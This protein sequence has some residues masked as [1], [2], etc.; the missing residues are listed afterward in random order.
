MDKIQPT[1]GFQNFAVF[2][3]ENIFWSNLNFQSDMSILNSF[4]WIKAYTLLFVTEIFLGLF[5]VP[6]FGLVSTT[7]LFPTSKIVISQGFGVETNLKKRTNEENFYVL[8]IYLNL[9]L[10][11]NCFSTWKFISNIDLAV[12]MIAFSICVCHKIILL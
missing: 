11:L 6:F 4:Y 7:V 3:V 8:K 10:N 5:F 12:W 2:I 1:L 9:N